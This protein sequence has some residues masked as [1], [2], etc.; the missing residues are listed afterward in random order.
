MN[1][2]TNE[3]QFALPDSGV[4]DASINILKFA[5]LGTSLV[6]TRSPLADGETL[7]S[8]FE[9]QLKKLEQQVQELRYQPPQAIQ[10]G[11]ARDVPA[12][13]VQNQFHKGN[14]HVYQ[15]QLV[16]V[17]PGTRNLLALSYVKNQP[18]GAEEAEHWSA[19]KAS[20]TFVNTP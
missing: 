7:Q 10:V 17:M 9:G 1:Y 2:R 3:A 8:N 20:L 4:Q 12:L 16:L 6:V 15:Y 5:N 19:I 13:E 18:L 14:D 11:T